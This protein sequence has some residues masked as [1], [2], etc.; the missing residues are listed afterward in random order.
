[1]LHLNFFAS[2]VFGLQLSNTVLWIIFFLLTV[3][4]EISALGF[5]DKLSYFLLPHFH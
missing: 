3:N 4:P 1:M 2:V 5:R